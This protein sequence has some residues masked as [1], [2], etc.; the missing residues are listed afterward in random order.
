MTVK[1]LKRE[2]KIKNSTLK[3]AENAMTVPFIICLI[4]TIVSFNEIWLI[5][6]IIFALIQSVL[7][8]INKGK[9]KTFLFDNRERLNDE[10]RKKLKL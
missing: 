10:E 5:L 3:A 2:F 4:L 6:A 9:W 1:E 8:T 7:Y